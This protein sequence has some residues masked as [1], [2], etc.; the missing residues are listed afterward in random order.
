[1]FLSYYLKR[2]IHI[3]EVCIWICIEY[4]PLSKLRI[5]HLKHR[6]DRVPEFVAGRLNWL[7]PPPPP[8]SRVY[9]QDLIGGG[10]GDTHW[11]LIFST[12]MK[13]F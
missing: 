10:G 13:N 4:I 8:Q 1:M 12:M 9:P 5:Y 3:G 6:V 2:F 7:P 11:I